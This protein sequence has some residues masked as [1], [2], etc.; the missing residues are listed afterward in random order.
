MNFSQYDID[1]F[2]RKV[3]IRS[4]SECWEWIA[5]A[6]KWGYGYFTCQYKKIKAHRFSAYIADMDIKDKCVCHTCDNPSCVN[7]AHLFT[8]TQADNM[9]DRFAKGRIRVNK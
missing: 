3:D 8:G 1:R 7:P 2:W 5:P 6:D 9:R 4:D